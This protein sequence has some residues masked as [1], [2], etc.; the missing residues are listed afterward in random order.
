MAVSLYSSRVVLDVLGIS[1]YGIYVLVGGVVTFFG[2]F[3]KAMASSTQRFLS[4]E[5]GNDNYDRLIQIFSSTI[6]I[7]FGIAVLIFIL[8]E[9]IGLWYINYKLV[10]PEGSLRAVNWIYQFSILT[11]VVGIFQVPYNA[12]MIARER[13]NVYAVYSIIE[14]FLK[15]IILYLLVISPLDKLITY[16]A[17]IFLVTCI[18][19]IL[20]IRYCIVNFSES[21]YIYFY[22]KDLYKSLISY[23]G[24][25]LFGNIAVV[26]KGQGTNIVLNL[27]FGTVVNAAY[28]ISMQAQAA[29]N[30]F[31]TNFQLA[32]NPQIIQNYAIGNY[33]RMHSL[34]ISSSKISFFL[35]L[36]LSVPILI[37]L[38]FILNIWLTKVPSYT[39]EFVFLTLLGILISSISGPLMT[40]IQATGKIKWYQIV[41]GFF[42]F[43]NLPV[44]YFVLKYFNN[45][46]YVFLVSISIHLVSLFLRMMYVEKYLELS[47]VD[48][49]VKVLSK[50]CIVVILLVGFLYPLRFLDLAT[51]SWVELIVSSLYS[52]VVVLIL[53]FIVGL[54]FQE[55]QFLKG[56]LYNRSKK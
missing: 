42:V 37:N 55:K 14:V 36:L 9:T 45:P 25:N 41:V 24:W 6:N 31:V 11:F 16:A 51:H 26:A 22:E 38:H 33:K 43:L 7:H 29:L 15:L 18:I 40:G 27:F 28:G 50:I 52:I 56:F 23:S 46:V 10:V 54:D 3:N 13:M 21:R 8:T 2:F 49:I 35:M 48:Y 39:Y 4:I 20:Y 5:I 12:L 47:K 44:S 32:V 53:I 30:V 19:T 1:D 17:L 34:I